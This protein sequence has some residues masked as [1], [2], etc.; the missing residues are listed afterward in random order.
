MLRR[1]ACFYSTLMFFLHLSQFLHPQIMH[2]M[3]FQ[4]FVP[5]YMI[6]AYCTS[7][8]RSSILLTYTLFNHQFFHPWFNGC[9]LTE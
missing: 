6:F 4:M 9:M 5:M 3:I 1:E 8:L 2:A 7:E